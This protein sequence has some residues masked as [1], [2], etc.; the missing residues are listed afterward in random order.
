MSTVFFFLLVI[1]EW[2]A[3]AYGHNLSP[4]VYNLIVGH[5]PINLI[6][7]MLDG[8][9][10]VIHPLLP[11]ILLFHGIKYLFMARANF[12]EDRRSLFYLGIL[13]E[14]GYLAYGVMHMP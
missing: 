7:A 1:L 8:T 9:T 14:I 3:I 4:E 12:S 6:F 2:L 11:L 10:E 5:S 13:L